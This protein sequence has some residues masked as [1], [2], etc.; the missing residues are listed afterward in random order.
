MKSFLTILLTFCVWSHIAAQTEPKENINIHG[1]P[2]FKRTDVVTLH[3]K[4]IPDEYKRNRITDTKGRVL[5]GDWLEIDR[6][7][8]IVKFRRKDGNQFDIAF[9]DLCANDRR[10]AE[11]ETGYQWNTGEKPPVPHNLIIPSPK[12]RLDQPPEQIA[13]NA[14]A[15][16]HIIAAKMIGEETV[17]V[18]VKHD[19]PKATGETSTTTDLPVKYLT[20]SD[21]EMIKNATNLDV[22]VIARPAWTK[23]NSKYWVS[24]E[25]VPLADGRTGRSRIQYQFYEPMPTFK[26]EHVAGRIPM[27]ITVWAQMNAQYSLEEIY[28]HLRV[29]TLTSDFIFKFCNYRQQ[30]NLNERRSDKPK[31][32]KTLAEVMKM[33]ADVEPTQ[34]KVSLTAKIE[35]SGLKLFDEKT[36]SEEVGKPKFGNANSL[37]LD[38]HLQSYYFIAQYLN[39]ANGKPKVPFANFFG[40]V[41]TR[42][43]GRSGGGATGFLSFDM[44]EVYKRIE[45]T[46]GIKPWSIPNFDNGWQKRNLREFH[47]LL[48]WK[49]IRYHLRH[50][51]PVFVYH[52]KGYAILTGYTIE[53]GKETTYEAI[54]LDGARSLVDVSTT[55]LPYKVYPA[56]NKKQTEFDFSGGVVFL[57]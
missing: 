43:I 21:R 6:K 42:P 15:N 51:Q 4:Q 25:N 16:D 49:L 33:L 11:L 31:N 17:Q 54:M 14:F 12:D 35:K 13:L 57:E 36:P 3:D 30:L 32:E 40:N 48:A 27:F 55:N 5:E 47:D 52:E 50:N 7:Q 41:T 8:K 22:P 38:G 2:M 10:Y 18:T 46:F 19:K 28:D 23:E 20:A 34:E 56:L 39:L 29:K 24:W 44:D 26:P 1:W 37:P 9:G 53:P 45:K